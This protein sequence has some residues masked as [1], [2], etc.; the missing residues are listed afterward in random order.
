MSLPNAQA[1]T[2]QQLYWLLTSITLIIASHAMNLPAWVLI[3]CASLIA[4]RGVAAKNNWQLPNRWTIFG[5]MVLLCFA[6]AISFKSLIGRDASLSLLLTMAA[7]KLIETKTKRDYILLVILGF[8]L[9]GNLFLFN[10]SIATFGLSLLPLILLTATLMNISAVKTYAPLYL[11][12]LAG[13]ILLHALPVTLILF[14]LFPR[15]PGPLWALPQDANSG[16]T[17]LDDNLNFGNISHLVQNGSIAFRVQ[18]KGQIPPKHL[19]YWRG[20]VLWHQDKNSWLMSSNKIGLAKESLQLQSAAVDYTITLEPHNR[21]WMLT[22]DMPNQAPSGAKL[23]HDHSVMADEPIRKRIRYVV[24]SYT[25]YKLGETLAERERILGLQI[26]E[27]ENPRTMQLGE[28]WQALPPEVRINKALNMYR[29]EAFVYTLKP[30]K[31]GQDGVDTFLFETKRG[32]CEHYAASFVYLMRAAGVPAR[33]VTGYQGGEYNA[34]GNYLIVRQS[35]AHAWA[36]VWLAGKG[37]VRVDPTAAV[38]PERV[39]QSIGDAINETDQLPMLARPDLPWLRKAFLSWDTINNG[40]NQWVLGYDDQKQIDLL[41]KLTGRQFT[42]GE[43]AIW[44]TIIAATVSVLLSLWLFNWSKPKCTPVQ[45]LYA[46]HIAWL[47]K[48]GIVPN[49]GEP[50]IDFAKRAGIQLPSQASQLLAI[51]ECYNQLQYSQHDL[52]LHT[53]QQYIQAFKT[54]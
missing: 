4:Y 8:F 35:D 38:A 39:E 49:K 46:Q 48:H 18:F 52:K 32:F 27:G 19:L 9:L 22:L 28:S 42:E 25:N 41:Q 23:S 36:E 50:A 51:A 1:L 3:V 40:W 15:I 2:R 45:K 53:L 34:N 17:G 16:M 29:N 26:T 37:W 47:K 33:I 5:M 30:P 54:A 6:L 14:V 43:L 24:R 12:K 20:P 31:L 11:F 44:M 13:K 10:Q 7:L 21:L